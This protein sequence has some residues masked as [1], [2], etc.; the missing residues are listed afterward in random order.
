MRDT[1]ERP[2]G[3]AAGT[4]LLTDPNASAIVDHAM[5]LLTGEAAYRSMATT[6]NPYGGRSR[7]CADRG[8]D[9]PLFCSRNPGE[10][11]EELDYGMNSCGV[12][13]G[14]CEQALLP[15]QAN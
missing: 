9:A 5:R 12:T 2:E 8:A 1:T 15:G 13:L 3:V 6:K 4:G 10:P 11:D 7:G 14:K